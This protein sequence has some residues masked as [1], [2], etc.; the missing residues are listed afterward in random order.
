MHLKS[1]I[2]STICSW[3]QTMMDRKRVSKTH[4]NVASQIAQKKKELEEFE[5]KLESATKTVADREGWL[6]TSRADLKE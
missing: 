5:K 1:P 2:L 3:V 4:G 6:S